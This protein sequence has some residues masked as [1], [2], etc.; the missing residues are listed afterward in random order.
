MVPNMEL[1]VDLVE[2]VISMMQ[3]EIGSLREQFQKIPNMEQTIVR[4][5]SCL[6]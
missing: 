3:G 6:V 4:I 1:I 2:E 5:L